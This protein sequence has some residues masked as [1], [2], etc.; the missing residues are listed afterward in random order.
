[1]KQIGVFLFVFLL[2]TWMPGVT[3]GEE[4]VT[5]PP[6]PTPTLAP[7][8]WLQTWYQ[9]GDILRANGMYPFMELRKGDAGYEVRMLQTRL[10]QLGYY[11]K[12]IVDNYGTGTY[13]AMR[14]FEKQNHLT[15]NGI[16]SIQDQKLL[17]STLA[18]SSSGDTVANTTDDNP[19]ATGTPSETDSAGSPWYLGTLHTLNPDVI[20]DLL[21]TST[22][23]ITIFHPK[24]TLPAYQVIFP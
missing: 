18:L 12:A 1:M 10:S 11:R 3:L 24:V 19:T 8:E 5:L 20:D 14:Q 16:A 7:E 6:N 15:V 2:L 4:D 17:Y 23:V 13:T 9:I 21:P 22:P